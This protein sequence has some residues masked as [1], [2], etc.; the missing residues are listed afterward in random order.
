[1]A[2]HSLGLAKTNLS[3]ESG[4]PERGVEFGPWR[5]QFPGIEGS[6]GQAF[7]HSRPQLQGG[8]GTL[9]IP[10]GTG[11]ARS[12]TFLMCG[13]VSSQLLRFRRP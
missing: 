9:R 13:D 3:F 1:M 12:P 11:K 4:P 10:S 2:L 8:V 7:S 6:D 5:Q